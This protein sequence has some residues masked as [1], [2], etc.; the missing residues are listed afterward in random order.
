MTNSSKSSAV[1]LAAVTAIT[2][3]G[4]SF[5]WTNILL[6][7]QVPV[8]TFLFIRLAIAGI[9]LLLFSKAIGKLQPVTRTDL[10]WMSLMAFFEPFIYFIGESYGMKATHSPTIS[11]VIIASIPIFCLFVEKIIYRIP[12]TLYKVLGIILTLPGI[13]LMVFEDGPVS[14]EHAYG[15]ALL[16]MAVAGATGYAT[17]VRKL[18]DKYNTYTIATYQ[19]LV[20]ALLFLPFFL[21]WG[22][23]GI[24]PLFFTWTIQLPLLSLAVLCSCVA[25]C[26][27]ILVIRNIGITRANMF[28]TL[29]PVVSAAGAALLGQ[30]T[31]TFSKIAGMCIVI[32]G[33][34]LAQHS[35]AGKTAA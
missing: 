3:W 10:L 18:S 7:H 21:I 8:F 12:F 17:V 4:F 2:L 16:F 9:L 24:T 5:V 35:S 33:V 6:N 14:A 29:I 26:L 22:A 13:L 30:E 1:Y 15:I 20:G 28:S 31:V 27:Y 23:D 11:A 25:F 34:V 32:A 19:F